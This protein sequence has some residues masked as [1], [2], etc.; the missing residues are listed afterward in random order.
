MHSAGFGAQSLSGRDRSIR[1]FLSP[2]LPGS[3]RRAVPLPAV[4]EPVGDLRG[5][6][7][8]GLGQLPLLARRRVR[9]VVV[10]LAQHLKERH[11]NQQWPNES[12]VDFDVWV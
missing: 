9:V 7:P 6:E 10:P 11:D 8:G 2:S 3:L 4:L 5:G 1:S 12:K